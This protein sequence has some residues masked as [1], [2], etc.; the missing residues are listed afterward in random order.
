MRSFACAQMS[1]SNFLGGMS[2]VCF[3]MAISVGC[4]LASHHGKD[5]GGYPAGSFVFDALIGYGWGKYVEWAFPELTIEQTL[6]AAAAVGIG[7]LVALVC[8]RLSLT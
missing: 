7:V 3:V 8:R 4:G 6:I 2:V 1:A 5:E